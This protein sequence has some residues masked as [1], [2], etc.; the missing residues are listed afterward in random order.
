MSTAKPAAQ[1]Q[2][3]FLNILWCKRDSGAGPVRA[4]TSLAYQENLVWSG[5]VTK[6]FH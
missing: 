3:I 2:L 1:V 4:G 6:A 5:P